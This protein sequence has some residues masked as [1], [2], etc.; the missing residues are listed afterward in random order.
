MEILP[1]LARPFRGQSD[2][3]LCRWIARGP[4]NGYK[5]D[6]GSAIEGLI[7]PVCIEVCISVNEGNSGLE[8]EKGAEKREMM[9]EVTQNGQYT[10]ITWAC[11]M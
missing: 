1:G 8:T 6:D 4:C 10:F 3:N 5:V 2:R 7:G 9:D 11:T